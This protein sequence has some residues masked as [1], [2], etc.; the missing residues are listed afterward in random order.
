M[1]VT[2]L[3]VDAVRQVVLAAPAPLTSG[4]V[5]RALGWPERIAF[6]ALARLRDDAQ[7]DFTVCPQLGTLWY[8]AES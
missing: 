2:S 4:E 3:T 1:T 8:R 6:T 7:V 5:A